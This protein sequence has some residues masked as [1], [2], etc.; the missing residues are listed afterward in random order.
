MK[1]R[2]AVVWLGLRGG[3]G[4]GVS[5]EF[6][7]VLWGWGE[8]EC[9]LCVCVCVWCYKQVNIGQSA[10]NRLKYPS[11]GFQRSV[12]DVAVGEVVAETQLCSWATVAVPNRR[13]FV[14]KCGSKD[15]I[16]DHS[17][18]SVRWLPDSVRGIKTS[19]AGKTQACALSFLNVTVL[20]L[21][22]LQ[23]HHPPSTTAPPHCQAVPGPGFAASMFLRQADIK[24]WPFRGLI[25]AVEAAYMLIDLQAATSMWKTAEKIHQASKFPTSQ[26]EL[27]CSNDSASN[28]APRGRKQ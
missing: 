25:W 22:G 7:N 24:K 1:P 18:R 28:A 20:D 13:L 23:H 3:L 4:G 2:S 27:T 17:N 8:A 11:F 15:L 26:S 14:Q 12:F 9:R 21:S 10:S 6:S 19:S 5:G 16:R